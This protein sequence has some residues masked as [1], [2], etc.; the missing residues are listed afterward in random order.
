MG[1]IGWHFF[2]RER[3]RKHFADRMSQSEASRHQPAGET[4]SLQADAAGDMR[5]RQ[6]A[7]S[8]RAG[9]SPTPQNKKTEI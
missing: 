9:V 3:S 8:K 5:G 6:Y 1:D 2:A 7:P 4:L